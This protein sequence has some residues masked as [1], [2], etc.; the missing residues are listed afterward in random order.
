[1]SK[2]SRELRDRH[3]LVLQKEITGKK[4]EI[5]QYFGDHIRVAL[6]LI[7]STDGYHFWSGNFHR[8]LEDIEVQRIISMEKVRKLWGTLVTKESNESSIEK[9]PD[10]TLPNSPFTY[11]GLENIN[12]VFTKN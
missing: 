7:N 12:Y 10:I 11:F 2:K 8:S 1:M 6:Q 5:L 3:R 4:G 9:Q